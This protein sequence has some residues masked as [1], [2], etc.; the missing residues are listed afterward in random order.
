MAAKKIHAGNFKPGN[1]SSK[2]HG[3][4]KLSDGN[5]ILAKEVFS[6]EMMLTF[7]DVLEMPLKELYLQEQNDTQSSYRALMVSAINNGIQTGDLKTLELVMNR[8]CGKVK[9]TVKVETDQ[10]SEAKQYEEMKNELTML[11]MQG[12]Q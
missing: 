7:I 5:A 4:P 1:Q 9:D 11:I 8:I 2:G 6:N 10:P 12:L 3:R